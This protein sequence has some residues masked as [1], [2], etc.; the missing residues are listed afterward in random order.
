[1]NSAL[2]QDQEDSEEK[3]LTFGDYIFDYDGRL[4]G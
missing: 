4:G 2:V 1:M 3:N